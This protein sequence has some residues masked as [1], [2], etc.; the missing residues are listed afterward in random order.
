MVI[1]A[2]TELNENKY[3]VNE[4]F[5]FIDYRTNKQKNNT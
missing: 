5:L 1:S 4:L 2:K 3:H